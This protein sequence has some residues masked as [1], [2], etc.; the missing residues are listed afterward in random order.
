MKKGGKGP[1]KGFGFG[2]A[3]FAI[4]DVQMDYANFDAPSS[5]PVGVPIPIPKKNPIAQNKPKPM[6]PVKP[7]TAA[8]PKT[9]QQHQVST[10]PK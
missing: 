1:A 5:E 8:K 2:D 10:L 6:N 9:L 3:M 4:K 7:T